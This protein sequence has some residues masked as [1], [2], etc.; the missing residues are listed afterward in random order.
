[1]SSL[2]YG[3]LTKDEYSA[4]NGR[5]TID[6]GGHTYRLK[7][8]VPIDGGRFVNYQ[9]EEVVAEPE[10]A[11]VLFIPSVFIP[12]PPEELPDA[13]RWAY[14]QGYTRKPNAF[15]PGLARQA[16]IR[17]FGVDPFPAVKG[18]RLKVLRRELDG[19]ETED[20]QHE[21]LDKIEKKKQQRLS[22]GLV[23]NDMKRTEAPRKRSVSAS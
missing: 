11:P 23:R 5:D 1:M 16:Y 8:T 22:R 21:A 2:V 20:K 10:P 3:R 17:Q 18:P 4:L 7:E 12:V 19:A 15:L 6:L 13:R 9:A 14:E